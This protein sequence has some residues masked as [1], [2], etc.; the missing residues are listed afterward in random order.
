MSLCSGFLLENYLASVS[1][2]TY[3]VYDLETL[4]R[5]RLINDL[6]LYYKIQN[7]QCDMILNVAPGFSVTRGNNFKLAKQTYSID[8]RK[9][10][11]CNRIVDAWN[12]LP[13]AVFAASSAKNFKMNLCKVNFD[14][15]LTIVE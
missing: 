7:G 5:R 11:Y 1:C 9:Y 12:S 4:E 2:H 8:V 3:L 10:F 15:F 13:N 6:V 14:K